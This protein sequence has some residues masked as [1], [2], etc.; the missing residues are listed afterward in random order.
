MLPAHFDDVTD[1]ISRLMKPI[2]SKFL[3]ELL[4]S[5]IR[6]IIAN[7]EKKRILHEYHTNLRSIT[8]CNK[9]TARILNNPK[10]SQLS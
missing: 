5:P 1:D 10:I 2:W 7:Y 9:S 6:N 3:Q 8:R 4:Q